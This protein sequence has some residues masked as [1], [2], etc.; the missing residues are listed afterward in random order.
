MLVG[1]KLVPLLRIEMRSSGRLQLVKL[2][3]LLQ[4]FSLSSF[5]IMVCLLSRVKRSS[6]SEMLVKE[7]ARH[8]WKCWKKF[9][10]KALRVL[11][12]LLNLWP[13]L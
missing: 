13:W 2:W 3:I 10:F 9:R 12:R 1:M 5:L 6:K 8:A 11:S 4:D 7:R